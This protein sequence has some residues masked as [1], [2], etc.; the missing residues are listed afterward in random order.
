MEEAGRHVCKLV[1]KKNNEKIM[2]VCGR[3]DVLFLKDRYMCNKVLD[4]SQ[5]CESSPLE[6]KYYETR[7]LYVWSLCGLF[8]LS[9]CK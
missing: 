8:I 6:H 3:A 4:D 9:K 2:R 7:I 1:R 5:G